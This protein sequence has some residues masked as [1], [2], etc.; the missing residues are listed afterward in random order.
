MR[1]I[2]ATLGILSFASLFLGT[3]IAIVFFGYVVAFKV[4]IA[5][6]LVFVFCLIVNDNLE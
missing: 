5:S 6:L 2:I 1:L 4:M 3:A